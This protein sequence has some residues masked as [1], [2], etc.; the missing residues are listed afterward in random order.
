MFKEIPNFN[1]YLVNTK[2]VI[3]NK[4]T[5]KRLTPNNTGKG[6]MQVQFKD[7][8]NYFEYT[9]EVLLPQ[10]KTGSYL[11]YFES[12]SSLKDKNAFAY[13]TITISNLSLLIA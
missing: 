9:T 1:E 5:R 2:G 7:K 11:V 6:Y 10:L 13:E 3:L 4:K 12:D 8:K